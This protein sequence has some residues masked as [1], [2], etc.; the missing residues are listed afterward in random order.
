M[1]WLQQTMEHGRPVCAAAGYGRAIVDD[2]AW[3]AV[4]QQLAS[5]QGSMLGLWGDGECVHL[6]VLQA[7]LIGILTHACPSRRFP[8]IG[9]LYPP[10][11]RL[12]RAI[13]DLYGL[14]P[15]AS[16]D[17]RAWLDHG[18]WGVHQPLGRNQAAAADGAPYAFHAAEG[19]LMHLIPV[20]P[21]HA[22]IIEPGH[23]RF[24]ANGET[25]VRLEQR[26]GYVHKGIDA[27]LEGA[28]LDQAARIAARVSGDTTVAYGLAFSR[29]VEAATGTIVSARAAHLRALMLELER[30]ANH[31][32]DIGAICNDA[33]FS[34]MHAHCAVLRERVLRASEAAFGHRLMM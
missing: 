24:T 5:G 8:A 28:N 14:E 34:F 20:G 2:A 3:I 30:I 15:V 18:R 33:S 10:A 16:P 19:P 13:H 11:L 21:V 23:F 25:I 22:G 27:L 26:L 31:L 4:A 9:G 6:C 7:P 32:G 17:R 29:A 12:E 1:A